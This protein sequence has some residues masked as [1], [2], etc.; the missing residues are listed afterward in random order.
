[1]ALHCPFDRATRR[2]ALLASPFFQ[3]MRPEE[4]LVANLDDPHYLEI[5]CAGN[6]DSLPAL[7]A[8]NWKAGQAIRAERRKKISNHP[9]PIR[10]KILRDG[11]ALPRLKRAVDTVVAVAMPGRRHAA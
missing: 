6:L 3:A 5:L 1:M 4:L 2:E 8:Q 9:I 7:F 10:T 11:E